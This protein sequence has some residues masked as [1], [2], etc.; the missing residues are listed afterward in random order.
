MA[1]PRRRIILRILAAL[2]LLLVVFVAAMPLWF[3]WIMRPAAKSLG[4]SYAD[5]KRDGYARFQ[6]TDAVMK[7]EGGTFDARRIEAYVPT[8]WLWKIV[9]GHTN[10]SFIQVSSWRFEI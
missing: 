7:T 3:P 6:I 2:V 9:S 10:R 8:V 1:H 4:F 5:Y